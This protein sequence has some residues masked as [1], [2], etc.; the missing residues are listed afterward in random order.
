MKKEESEKEQSLPHILVL[1]SSECG[2]DPF[3][4]LLIAL[5]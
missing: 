5:R 3:A 1:G 4:Y 2:T